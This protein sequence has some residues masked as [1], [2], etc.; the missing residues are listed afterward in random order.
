MVT[1]HDRNAETDGPASFESGSRKRARAPASICDRDRSLQTLVDAW[2]RS[3]A[4]LPVAVVVSIFDDLLD[5]SARA[6]GALARARGDLRL[7][8]EEAS[9]RPLGLEDVRVD[10]AGFARIARS[11]A[12]IDT[13]RL[14]PLLLD[15]LGERDD[16]DSMPGHAR[17]RL[18]RILSEGETEPSLAAEDV[19]AWLRDAFGPPGSREEVA[20]CFDALERGGGEPVDPPSVAPAKVEPVSVAD[21]KASGF[22]E[23]HSNAPPD[24]P[25]DTLV[26]LRE[27]RPQRPVIRHAWRRGSAS[28]TTAPA[29][30]RSA[31]A[32]ANGR[33]ALGLPGDR[34][35]RLLW[36][37]GIAIASAGALVW[38]SAQ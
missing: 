25:S 9:E 17:A 29:A 28:V 31:R 26:P 10:R 27:P 4:R 34:R 32:A 2:G 15:A 16:M 20:G 23:V 38:M 35:V 3:G 37:L 19:R 6:A 22:G 36:L 21:S 8:A 33:D 11:S 14:V 18:H 5:E 12:P 13:P 30:R 24:D 1:T 7:G